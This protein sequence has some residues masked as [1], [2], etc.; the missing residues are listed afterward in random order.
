MRWQRLACLFSVVL[1]VALLLIL[2]VGRRNT[3]PPAVQEKLVISGTNIIRTNV[4]VQRQFFH[5]RQLESTDYAKYVQNLREVG[6]PDSTI[7]DIILGDVNQLFAKRLSNELDHL[8]KALISGESPTELPT[9][10]EI[11]HRLDLERSR[12]LTELLGTNWVAADLPWTNTFRPV[13]YPPAL[14]DEIFGVLPEEV[15]VQVRALYVRTWRRIQEHV[16]DRQSRGFGPEPMVILELESEMQKN[17]AQYLTATQME[18]F[19]LRYSLVGRMVRQQLEGLKYFNPS[20]EEIRR[21]FRAIAKIE[22]ELIRLG[23]KED[24]R[25]EAMRRDLEA[26]REQSIKLALGN[27]RYEEFCRLQDPIFRTAQE[28]ANNAG[29]PGLGGVIYELLDAYRQEYVS[30]TNQPISDVQ[31]QI[32]ALELQLELTK[33]LGW[34]KGEDVE[35]VQSNGL[36]FIPHRVEPGETVDKLQARYGISLGDILQANPGLD[37]TR[38]KPGDVIMVP[39]RRP[40]SR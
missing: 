9:P 20:P 23:A 34:V 32:K 24:S 39:I 5:W 16:A 27:A 8:E 4:I 17:L 36:V 1:N 7:C 14:D 11:L 37:L 12:L 30:L 22:E 18:E 35:N 28:I 13:I 2:V 19:L 38:V 40:G 21:V 33:A 3:I 6:C 31:R 29:V 26:R 15:K 10:Q 25:S